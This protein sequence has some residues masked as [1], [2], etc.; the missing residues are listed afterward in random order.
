MWEGIVMAVKSYKDKNGNR[1]KADL[2]NYDLIIS[3]SQFK[4][5]DSYEN[6]EKYIENCHNNNILWGVANYSP[7]Y[8]DDYVFLNYQFIQ[9]L[10]L[11]KDEI[12]E[13][14]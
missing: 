3:E 1:I 5:W 4:L 10:N 8:Y 12:K 2:R 9:S 14:C 6:V 13:L 11:D 7:E